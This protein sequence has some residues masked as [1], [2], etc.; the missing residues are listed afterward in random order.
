ME[1]WKPIPDFE[2][3]Y[4][5]S[6]YGQVRRIRKGPHTQIGRVNRLFLKR[7]GYLQAA[8]CKDN[9]TSHLL[10]HRLVARMFIP[11]P[12]NKPTV[13]HKDGDKQNNYFENLEWATKSEQQ[14]HAYDTGLRDQIG[15][16]NAQ[17]KLTEADVLELRRLR[18]LGWKYSTL[19]EKFG[20][21]ARAA[22]LIGRRKRW[23]H[24]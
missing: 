21:H 5:I 14:Q 7:N 15:S 6:D 2:G 11:N 9:Q 12:H 8:L 20:I 22:G 1:T 17:A 23:T 19:G 10:V 24:I 3:W 4:E 18:A 13:N 16:N